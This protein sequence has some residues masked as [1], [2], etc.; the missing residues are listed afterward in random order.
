MDDTYELLAEVNSLAHSN[1]KW[2]NNQIELEITQL[3]KIGYDAGEAFI[4]PM[5]ELV[6]KYDGVFTKLCKP[7]ARDIKY[8][9]ELLDPEKPITHQKLKRMSE[10]KIKKIQKYLQEYLEKG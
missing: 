2:H 5:H 4:A 10:N 7:V 6:N 3:S 1:A 8:K 9:I